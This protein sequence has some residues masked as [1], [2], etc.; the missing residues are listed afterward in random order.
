M[1]IGV[2]GAAGIVEVLA[3]MTMDIKGLQDALLT[4]VVVTILQGD[5]HMVEGQG[6]T[7]PDPILLTAVLKGTIPVVLGEM[8]VGFLLHLVV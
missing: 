1:V 3:V 5:H 7:G 6:G 8:C 4:E 2:I